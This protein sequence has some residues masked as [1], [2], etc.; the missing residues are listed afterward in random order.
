MSNFIVLWLQKKFQFN[1]PGFSLWLSMWSLMENVP[2]AFEK[3]VYS[4]TFGWNALY[5]WIKSIR[6]NV[7]FKAYVSL[8]TFFSDPFIEVS[9][10][11]KSPTI[12]LLLLTCVS[13]TFMAVSICLI[14][15]GAPVLGRCLFATVF[16]F[17]IDPLIM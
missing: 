5:I 12:L 7:S 1:M 6:A 15:W 16:S 3:N 11:L 8:L 17:W 10:A 9:G 2:Y 14:Y 4:A 13:Y